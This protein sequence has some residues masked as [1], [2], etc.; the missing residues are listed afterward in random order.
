MHSVAMY[1]YTLYVHVYTANASPTTMCCSLNN[2]TYPLTLHW[3][4]SYCQSVEW[5]AMNGYTG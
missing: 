1:I 3:R 2:H 5:H 4:V